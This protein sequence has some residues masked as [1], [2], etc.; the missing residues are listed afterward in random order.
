M[1]CTIQEGLDRLEHNSVQISTVHCRFLTQGKIKGHSTNLEYSIEKW[2]R[3]ELVIKEKVI[4]G[5]F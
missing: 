5:H 3:E 1:P 4:D 2:A